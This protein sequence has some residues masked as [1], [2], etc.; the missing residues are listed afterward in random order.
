MLITLHTYTHVPTH[1]Q[2][3][4][5][6]DSDGGKTADASDSKKAKKGKSLASKITDAIFDKFSSFFMHKLTVRTHCKQLVFT[7][8]LWVHQLSIP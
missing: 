4:D 7:I 3:E 6:G 1:I 8:S 2:G 5:A